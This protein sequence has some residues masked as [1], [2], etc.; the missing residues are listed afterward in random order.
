MRFAG[1][2]RISSGGD[3]AAN[4]PATAGARERGAA[5]KEQPLLGRRRG[6][7]TYDFPLEPNRVPEVDAVTESLGQEA[8]SFVDLL[9]RR[10]EGFPLD[11]SCSLELLKRLDLTRGKDRRN[12][13]RLV[14]EH[15]RHGVGVLVGDESAFEQRVDEPPR[16]RAADL[17]LRLGPPAGA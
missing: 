2:R 16:R 8:A 11:T 5:V 4:G 13:G 10:L 7:G 14:S 9:W 12:R 6:T 3:S 1:C 17:P 15:Q